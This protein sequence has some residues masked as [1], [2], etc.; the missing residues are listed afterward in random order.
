MPDS[1]LSR[2]L[3]TSGFSGVTF[4]A[5]TTRTSSGLEGRTPWGMRYGFEVEATRLRN[6]FS[7]DTRDIVQQYQTFA[8]LTVV[9]PLL[10][11][12][13]PAANLAE[14]RLARQ[15]RKSQELNGKTSSDRGSKRYVDIFRHAFWRGGHEPAPGAVATDEKLVMQNQR[16]LDFGFGQRFDVEQARA[17]VS[18]DEEQFLSS[19]TFYGTAVRPQAAHFRRVR[20]E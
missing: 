2:E 7:G 9:Q 10:R 5:Q 20:P 8:G 13:G 15:T 3:S 11:N 1:Q 14:L 12:F 18:L 19:K 17:Q 4:D 16:R 6:T